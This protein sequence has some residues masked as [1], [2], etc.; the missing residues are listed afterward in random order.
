M[1]NP[2]TD[3]RRMAVHTITTRPL[4]LEQAVELYASEEIP[5]VTVWREHLEPYGAKKAAKIIKKAGLKVSGLCRGGF[6]VATG[7]MARE[8]ARAENRKIIDEAAELGAPVVVLVCGAVPG[9]PLTEARQQ[10][11]DGIH[12]IEPH[13]KAAGVK[14]AI[15]PLHPMYSDDRSAINTLDQANNLVMALGSSFVGVAID[16][17]HLWWDPYLRSEIKRT[18][19][20]IFSFHV[21]DWRTPTRDIL[22]DRGVMGEGCINVAEI[23]SWVDAAGFD[24]PIEVEIFSDEYWALD[25]KR[26]VKRIKHAYLNHT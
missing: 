1:S 16:V 24:G 15:E 4:N 10:I 18:T 21:C 12:S 26:F 13:A 22:N 3:T 17:Y 19:G 14:L 23:R 5:Y 20:S 2:L 7:G 25:Q 8:Q 9:M 11:L 6:F